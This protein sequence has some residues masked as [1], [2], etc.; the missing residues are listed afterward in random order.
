MKHTDQTLL[1]Q[2]QITDFEVEYRKA[3]F[4]ITTADAQA[5]LRIKPRLERNVDSLVARFYD[6]QTSIPE[7]ALLIDDADTL[8]RLR[9]LQRRYIIDLFSGNYDIEYVNNRL[10]I[11]QV[12]KRIGIAPKLY[13]SAMCTLKQL[14]ADLLREMVPEKTERIVAQSALDKVL[15]YDI[16]LFFETYMRSLVSEIETAR[17]KA[18]QHARALEEKV[19]QRTQQLEE[20]SRTDPLTGLLNMRDLT[21]T[22]AILLRTA[23]RRSEPVTVVYIDINDF[24]AINDA[25]GH[26]RGNEVL[27]EVARAIK[28]VLRIE[29]RCFR[30][31]GDEF[32]V[33]LSN[34]SEE[35]AETVYWPRVL[36]ELRKNQTG[37]TLSVGYA[38]TGPGDYALPEVLLRQADQ[39]M[40]AAKR[41]SKRQG[42]QSLA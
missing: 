20:L 16:T 42:A 4:S 23:A 11:G 30:Y 3:L 32:C 17:E 19:R 2:M 41:A 31:G 33:I 7:I 1:E 36:H 25:E 5:L 22:L 39:R 27:C 38:Q 13:L 21:E 9:T 28:S 18:E 8:A 14:L 34:C 40:Y 29:D 24:K 12:H 37:L 15:L 26:Q 35:Q 10:R 6:L